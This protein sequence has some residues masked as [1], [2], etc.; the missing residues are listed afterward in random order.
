MWGEE[1]SRDPVI[2]AN[3]G[4]PWQKGPL[5]RYSETAKERG[6]IPGVVVGKKTASV[7]PGDREALGGAGGKR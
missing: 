5:L 1:A 2:N 3:G 6:S 7:L 4:I